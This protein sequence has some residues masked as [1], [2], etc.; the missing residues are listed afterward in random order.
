MPACP[1][2]GWKG[3]DCREETRAHTREV[4]SV[5]DPIRTALERLHGSGLYEEGALVP[6]EVCSAAADSG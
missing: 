1:Q 4:W 6:A 5:T 2:Q 3:K